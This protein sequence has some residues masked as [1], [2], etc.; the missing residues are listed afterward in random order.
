MINSPATQETVLISRSVDDTLKIGEQ[1]AGYL[2]PGTVVALFGQLGSGKTVMVKGICRGLGVEEDEVSSPSF[3]IMNVYEGKVPV[4]HF[5]FYRIPPET[6]W[7][8]LGIE[9][10]FYDDGVVLIEWPDRLGDELPPDAVF[11]FIQRLLPF[12][13]ETENVR[14]IVVRNLRINSQKFAPYLEKEQ[15]D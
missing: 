3:T 5:D 11:V 12:A 15:A 6:D 2:G 4:F 14:K 7:Q 1:L 13:K 10:F 9:E 8:E